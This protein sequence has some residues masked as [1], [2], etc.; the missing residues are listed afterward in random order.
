MKTAALP[1]GKRVPV[2]GQGTWRMGE[3]RRVRAKEVAALRLGI[4]LG[5]TLIDTAEMYG[6]GGWRKRCGPVGRRAARAR[7]GCDESLSAQRM[8][9][10]TAKRLRPQF[11]TPPNRRD[12]S[13]PVAL[14]R[15][16]TASGGN[17]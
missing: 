3:D 13:L 9:L 11:E 5:M 7:V 8:A 16:E 2:L 10:Q 6:D 17:G 12:R 15:K 14:A 1:D 4:E